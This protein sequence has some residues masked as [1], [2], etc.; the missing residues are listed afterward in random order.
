[1]IAVGDYTMLMHII[2]KYAIHGYRRFYPCTGYMGGQ[3]MTYCG[4]SNQKLEFPGGVKIDVQIKALK[5][6]QESMTGARVRK[7]AMIAARDYGET[8]DTFAVTYGDGLTDVD[9]RH[10]LDAH[11]NF[12]LIGTGL[13]IH[14]PARFGQYLFSNHPEIPA[15]FA[16]KQLPQDVWINGGFFLFQKEFLDYIGEEDDCVLEQYPLSHLV[17]DRQLHAYKHEG[18]WAPMDTR[19]DHEYLEEIWRKGDAP[20]AKGLLVEQAGVGDGGN[21]ADRVN[22]GGEVA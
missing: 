22:A 3:I 9:L 11:F 10:Q 8:N 20:W 1:M 18:F 4:G 16:E 21:G 14:P 6:G 12:G 5:T 17:R 19:R 2:R 13:A 7:G 15:T